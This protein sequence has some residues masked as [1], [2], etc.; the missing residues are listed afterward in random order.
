[1]ALLAATATTPSWTAALTCLPPRQRLE[2]QRTITADVAEQAKAA[3]QGPSSRAYA[4]GSEECD[5][6]PGILG[7]SAFGR[8][9]TAATLQLRST[10]DLLAGMLVDAMA[11]AEV[12]PAVPFPSPARDASAADAESG[13]NSSSV[14]ERH[15]AEK[16]CVARAISAAGLDVA[17]APVALKTLQRRLGEDAEWTEELASGEGAARFP[18]VALIAAGGALVAAQSAAAAS[19]RRRAGMRGEVAPPASTGAGGPVGVDIDDDDAMDFLDAALDEV[20]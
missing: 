5:S 7:G 10:S 14:E 9:L 16:A 15:E 11:M 19:Q 1:M 17:Y 6:Q 12:E 8:H 18:G 2:W 4:S 3:K 20:M 13:V